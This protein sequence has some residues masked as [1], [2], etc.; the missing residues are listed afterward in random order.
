MYLSKGIESPDVV[1]MLFRSKLKQETKQWIPS[2]PLHDSLFKRTFTIKN[3]ESHCINQMSEVLVLRSNNSDIRNIGGKNLWK[4]F[5]A[6]DVH[7]EYDY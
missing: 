2:A 4:E 5:H 1:S 6:G 7:L 3:I